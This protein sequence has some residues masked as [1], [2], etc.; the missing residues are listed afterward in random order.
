MTRGTKT[1]FCEECNH[2]VPLPIEHQVDARPAW[3]ADL[4]CLPSVLAIPLREFAEEPHSIVR[5]HR[6]CDTVEILTRFCAMTTLGELR[7]RA[8]EKPFPEGFAKNLRGKAIMEPTFG[9]WKNLLI[10]AV[11]CLSGSDPLVVPEIVD[12]VRGS[13]LPI[14]LGKP[15]SKLPEHSLIE[16]R[17]NLAHGGAMTQAEASR[18]L[19]IWRPPLDELIGRLN[20]IGEVD[21]CHLSGAAARLL[22]GTSP[23]RGKDRPLSPS[24]AHAL[25]KLDGHVVLLRGDRWLDLWPLCDYG[26]ATV[27]STEGMRTSRTSGPLVYYRAETDRLLYAA[28]GVEFPLSEESDTNVL[29]QFYNLFRAE[30]EKPLRPGHEPDSDKEINCDKDMQDFADAFIGRRQVLDQAMAETKATESGVLWLTGPGGIGKSFLTAKL[31]F[32]FGDKKLKRDFWRIYWRFKVSDHSGANRV[33]FLRYAVAQLIEKLGRNEVVLAQEPYELERQ[34][35]ELLSASATYRYSN[36]NCCPR[37]L[38]IL[39][40]LDE[41]ARNDP[42][43]PRDIL[44]IDRQNFP[45]VIWLCAG[46]SEE[47]LGEIFKPSSRCRHVFEEGLPPMSERD[48]R[49]MLCHG[50]ELYRP[51]LVRHDHEPPDNRD[52]SAVTND[53][54][55]AVARNAAG[56]PLYVSLVIRDLNEGHYRI[57]DLRADRLPPSL[58]AYYDDLLRR[59]GVGDLQAIVSPL[60]VTLAWARAPLDERTLYELLRRRRLFVDPEAGR[61]LVRRGLDAVRGMIRPALLPGSPHQGYELYHSTLRKHIRDD[62]QKV[63]GQQ[64]PL[65]RDSLIELILDWQNLP[66]DHPARNYA[67]SQGPATLIEFESWDDLRELLLPQDRGLFFLEAK[68][69]AGLVFDLAMDLTQAVERMPPDHPA[70]RHLTL[71]EQTLRYDAHF[72]ACHPSTLFQCFWNRGWWYDCPEAARHYDPPDGGWSSAGPPW[73]QAGP[74]LHR[75]LEHWLEEKATRSPGFVWLRCLRPPADPLDRA[76]RG[77]WHGS[78]GPVRRIMFTPDGAQ[79]IESGPLF[80][81]IRVRNSMTGQIEREINCGNS[82]D[83]SANGKTLLVGF[84]RAKSIEEVLVQ[85]PEDSKRKRSLRLVDVTSGKLLREIPVPEDDEVRFSPDGRHA[86]IIASKFVEVRQLDHPE[87]PLGRFSIESEVNDY[88]SK[89]GSRRAGRRQR[90]EFG[91]VVILKCACFSRDGRYIF[92]GTQEG[93]IITLD[94]V[95]IKEVHRFARQMGTVGWMVHDLMVSP[96]GR[97]LAVGTERGM[98]LIDT[99][100][101]CEV[102]AFSCQAVQS[103]AFSTDS[104]RLIGGC[105]DHCIRVWDV[106]TKRALATLVGHRGPVMSVAISR[107]GRHLASGSSDRTVRLWDLSATIRQPTLRGHSGGIANMRFAADGSRLVTVGRD[108][109]VKVWNADSGCEVGYFLAEDANVNDARL[110]AKGELIVA[111]ILRE[112][113]AQSS[114]LINTTTGEEILELSENLLSLQSSAIG[115]DGDVLIIAGNLKEFAKGP[116]PIRPLLRIL[117]QDG[118][119]DEHFHDQGFICEMVGS[120]DG[121]M[122]LTGSTRSI[123]IWDVTNGTLLK[124]LEVSD[125]HLRWVGFSPE[126]GRLVQPVAVRHGKAYVRGQKV[127]DSET[128]NVLETVAGHGDPW[129]IA[130]GS[131]AYPF[132]PLI[133]SAELAVFEPATQSEIAWLPGGGLGFVVTHPGG[134]RFAIRPGGQLQIVVIEG[135][136][137]NGMTG[138]LS[139]GQSAWAP[140]GPS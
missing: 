55:E 63:I 75:L 47:N 112:E 95:T 42:D 45:N 71:L 77:E 88:K 135:T 90:D 27:A 101:L 59:L 80:S 35:T 52:P 15:P 10:A 68:A 4:S 17:N 102:P 87:P 93:P 66:V 111:T 84:G 56:L 83:L 46:R 8:G 60:V 85:K 65:A 31:A 91:P 62:T 129:A 139:T 41:I 22:V 114:R 29:E 40:G 37:V 96:D 14:L 70:R 98:R 21:L 92:I 99:G 124:T 136:R 2:S 11:D 127:V 116:T 39:D 1:W 130:T 100:Q 123:K 12:F 54:V 50:A 36:A 94:A 89:A 117:R 113:K 16:L 49:A 128:G 97:W 25:R 86:L 109:L 61:V 38:F 73:S 103:V 23:A 104:R 120:P 51:E 18:L 19:T 126:T 131:E 32:R 44:R 30:Q 76:L 64:N 121:R 53:L 115:R 43:F 26:Q 28:L 72:I 5:L 57:D 13:L 133:R 33:A 118:S 78:T 7:Q 137:P 79:V 9:K 119:S 125:E 107:D 69:E 140:R 134:S 58:N 20:F 74:K 81:P 138:T 24:L 48:V 34:L 122:V 132:W 108:D 106:D 67:I 82:F 3:L 6:L 110:N 105:E